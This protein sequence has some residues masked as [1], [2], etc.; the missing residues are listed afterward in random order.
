MQE[1]PAV[2]RR[3]HDDAERC[4]DEDIGKPL[5]V[6]RDPRAGAPEERCGSVS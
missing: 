6:G 4:G 2:D 3:A 1:D 5:L